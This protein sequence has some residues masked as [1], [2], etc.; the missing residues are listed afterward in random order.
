[1]GQTGLGKMLAMVSVALQLPELV[2]PLQEMPLSE[3][4]CPVVNG[5]EFGDRSLS[6]P[7]TKP[8][9]LADLREP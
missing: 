5:A 1:M 4:R 9:L 3:L 8:T 2:T 7:L 6:Y